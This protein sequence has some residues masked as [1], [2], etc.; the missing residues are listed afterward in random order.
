MRGAAQI[1]VCD[2]LRNYG[3]RS[4]SSLRVL[5]VLPD[6]C[7]AARV[8]LKCLLLGRALLL[9]LQTLFFAWRHVE[10]FSESRRALEGLRPELLR[11]YLALSQFPEYF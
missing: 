4:A 11:N 10:I 5:L 9:E 8:L 7:P 6:Q 2:R 1:S 3:G